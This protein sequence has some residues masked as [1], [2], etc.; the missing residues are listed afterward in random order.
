MIWESRKWRLVTRLMALVVAS[1]LMFAVAGPVSYAL[2]DDTPKHVMVA[3]QLFDEEGKPVTDRYIYVEAL[4]DLARVVTTGEGNS[5]HYLIPISGFGNQLFIYTDKGKYLFP[6]DYT[7]GDGFLTDS[8][9]IRYFGKVTTLQS[10]INAGE[11][12]EGLATQGINA[13]KDSTMVL[14]Q[15]E[16]PSSYRPMVPVMP[17]LALFWAVTLVG[18]WQIW[19]GRRPRRKPA[20]LT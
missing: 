11:A 16:E 18:A 8:T 3:R 6:F 12:F 1:I 15:G 13:D 10:Q 4:P 14:V 9:P 7:S 19:R 5:T 20:Y 17:A 2:Q